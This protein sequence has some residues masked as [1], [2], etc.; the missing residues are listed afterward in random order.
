MG[1][2]NVM[3]V[4]FYDT[5]NDELL[6]FAVIIS[7]S[8]GKWV[9]CKHKERDTYEVPGGHREDGENILETAKRELQEE[10]G[11]IKFEI[12]PICV[13][14]VTGKTRV[15]DTGEET[16]GLLCFAEI[17]EFAKELHSEMEKVV[18]MDELPEN[19]TYPLIQPKLIEKVFTGK[20]NSIIGTTVTVT[21]DRPL[22]SYH[23]EYKDMYYPINYGYIE[24]VMAPD[25]EEQDAYILGVNEPVKKFTGKIIAIVRRKDDIEEKW[26]VVPD[27][28]TFS[29]EE[30]RR[31]IHFQEQYLEISKTLHR[32]KDHT[33]DSEHNTKIIITPPKTESSIRIIPIPDFLFEILQQYVQ[34][35]TIDPEAYILTGKKKSFR[36][37]RSIEYYFKKT[38]KKCQIEPLHFHCLRHTFATRCVELG[39]DMKTLSE[40]LGHSNIN[41]TLNRYVHPSMEQKQQNMDKLNAVF[42]VK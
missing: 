2:E 21:V 18:L 40:I 35:H 4:K 38:L 16:F 15:N 7:Q 10:T 32:V 36:E 33:D 22:G 20:N 12:K 5:V 24:G 14:S 25:G 19:W 29:K 30:I 42:T 34:S 37:P 17:T 3:E 41:T 6:K 26:V 11:A 31:Q 27:G 1:R 39:F 13:Y 23:P 28:V 8:N 9:F